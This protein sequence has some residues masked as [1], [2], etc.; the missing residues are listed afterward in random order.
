MVFFDSNL[1]TNLKKQGMLPLTFKN[2]K[3]YERIAPSDSISIPRLQEQLKP[4]KDI[5]ITIHKEGG[6]EETIVCAHTFNDRQIEWFRAGS[7]L[8]R[9]AQ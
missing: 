1:E 5:S 2:P 6:K 3:D 9:M 8:N 7:A 4:G